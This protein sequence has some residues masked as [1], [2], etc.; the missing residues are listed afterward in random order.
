MLHYIC[1]CKR[2]HVIGIS[3][4]SILFSCIKV[5]LKYIE[6]Y[7]CKSKVMVGLMFSPAAVCRVQ[8]VL[9][10]DVAVQLA[11]GDRQPEQQRQSGPRHFQ[12]G[13]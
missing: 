9:R 7:D 5:M 12:P 1:E 4:F 11:D 6:K 2:T 8:A 10:G 13:E 3:L